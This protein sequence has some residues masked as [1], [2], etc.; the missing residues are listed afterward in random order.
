MQNKPSVERSLPHGEWRQLIAS[1]F[2]TSVIFLGPLALFC[3]LSGRYDLWS[4]ACSDPSGQVQDRADMLA[5]DFT[6]RDLEGRRFHLAE[7]VL[8][9][10][11]V[12]EIGSFS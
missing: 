12:L 4:W 8:K 5:P 3:I 9:S 1:C 11:V 6:L 10:P 7:E 2:L